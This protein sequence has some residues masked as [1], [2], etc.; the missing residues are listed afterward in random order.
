MC[1][2]AFQF[3]V[4]VFGLVQESAAMYKFRRM[5]ARILPDG[6]PS[7][8]RSKSLAICTGSS[9]SRYLR[10]YWSEICVVCNHGC[11]ASIINGNKVH[12]HACCHEM[13]NSY[14]SSIH[15][16]QL[17]LEDVNLNFQVL[18]EILPSRDDTLQNGGQPEIDEL[19]LD[20][21]TG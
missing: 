20:F 3:S 1:S 4:R 19:L 9:S 6:L 15:T 2:K 13:D 12:I 7:S 16:V 5:L 18:G 14:V 10:S 11:D 17:L 21:E 8:F